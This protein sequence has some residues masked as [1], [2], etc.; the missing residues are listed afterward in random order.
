MVKLFMTLAVSYK[1]VTLIFL[2]ALN[3]RNAENRIIFSRAK[4]LLIFIFFR[5]IISLKTCHL[6]LSY[7]LDELELVCY[8]NKFRCCGII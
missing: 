5:S 4:V 8:H 2:P 1:S 3:D 7:H 6:L